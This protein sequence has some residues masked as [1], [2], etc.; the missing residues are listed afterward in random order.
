L[1]HWVNLSDETVLT[2]TEDSSVTI[3]AFVDLST[4]STV[5]NQNASRFIHSGERQDATGGIDF[6]LQIKT[7]NPFV[8]TSLDPRQISSTTLNDPV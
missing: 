2:W 3:L 8:I 6:G 5:S 7:L 4:P 1:S